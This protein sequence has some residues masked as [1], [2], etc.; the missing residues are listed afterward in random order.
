MIGPSVL[1]E[2][3]S[4]LHWHR[5]MRGQPGLLAVVWDADLCHTV[6]WNGDDGFR[7]PIQIFYYIALPIVIL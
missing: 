5:V 3:G 4:A 7:L 2:Y 6:V 1:Y